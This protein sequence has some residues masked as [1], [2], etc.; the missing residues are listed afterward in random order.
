M[1]RRAQPFTQTDVT[2]V[3][4]ALAASGEKKVILAAGMRG[5][6][7]FR[8]FRHGGFTETGD[9]ELTDREIQAQGRKTTIKTLPRYVKKTTRQIINGT[10]KRRASRTKG[11]SESE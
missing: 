5:E 4:R 7:S 10:Q 9:A 2:K 8:S 11:V 1:S 3:L 6:L